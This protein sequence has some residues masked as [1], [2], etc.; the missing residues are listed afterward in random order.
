MDIAL[1]RGAARPRPGAQLNPD[2]P[3]ARFHRFSCYALE[4]AFNKGTGGPVFLWGSSGPKTLTSS[5]TPSYGSNIGGD[6]LHFAATSDYWQINPGNADVFPAT[7][8]TVAVIRRKLDT[9]ARAS[10]LF[11]TGGGAGN[12][13]GTHCPYSDS[14]VYWDFGGFSGSNR[15][16]VSISGSIVSTLETWVFRAGKLGSAIYRNGRVIASQSTA[17]SRSQGALNVQIN[18]GKG[19]G[20][21]LQQINQFLCVEAEWSDEMVAWWHA[22]PYAHLYQD[23]I[24]SYLFLGAAAAGSGSAHTFPAALLGA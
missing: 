10:T 3:F 4:G 18:Q 5:G 20:G 7:S 17:I 21:D 12:E 13:C 8:I 22:E 16:S 1:R 6:A 14:T 24:R 23:P 19:A 9:T 11:G 15:L 2:H